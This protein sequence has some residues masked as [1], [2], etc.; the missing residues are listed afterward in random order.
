VKELGA[1]AKRT[2]GKQGK[3]LMM[4][5]RLAGQIAQE[6]GGRNLRAE[7]LILLRIGLLGR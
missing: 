1:P 4:L 7:G 6:N 5:D 3:S 2:F